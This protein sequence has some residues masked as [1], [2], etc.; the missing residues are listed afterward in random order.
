MKFT[1]LMTNGEK[2]ELFA[3]D[4]N[5]ATRVAEKVFPDEKIMVITANVDIGAK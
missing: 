3:K 5:E 4:E 1:I 2:V